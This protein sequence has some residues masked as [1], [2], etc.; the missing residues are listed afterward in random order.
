MGNPLSRLPQN[1][2]DT[3]DEFF[4]PRYR[5]RLHRIFFES[6]PDPIIWS[7]EQGCILQVNPEAERQFGY[8]QEEL[9]GESLDKLIPEFDRITRQSHL[10]ALQSTPGFHPVNDGVEMFAYRKD[11]SDFPIDLILNPVPTEKGF[12]FYS[13]IRN[14]G[15]RGAAKRVRRHLAFEQAVVGLSARFINLPADRV[16]EEINHGLQILAEAMDADRVTFGKFDPTSDELVVTHEWVRSGFP[17]F[18]IRI[19]NGMLPWLENRIRQGIITGVE[20]PSDLP[21]EAEIERALMES[22]GVKSALVVPFR[23]GG[24]VTGGMGISFF[25]HHWNWD[26]I[27]LSRVKDTADIFA[28]ALARKRADADLQNALAEIRKLKDQLE[29]E[30]VYLRE[31]IKLDHAHTGVVANSVAMRGVLKKAEQVAATDSAV[32][33]LGET[34]TGKE[35][36]ARTI[37]D[38]SRRSSHSMI[39]I[40][41]AALPATLIESELFGREKG[42][43]TGA[44]ARQMGRFELA[45]H[46]TIFLDEIGELPPELQPKLLRVLQEGEFERLGSPRTLRVDAR[47]IAATSRDLPAMV[48]EGKFREDL[49][50]RLNI[51]PIVIPPLRVRPEDIPAL[52]WHILHDLGKRMGRGI[53]GVHA[54]TMR[55]FQAYDWPGNVRELRNVI[56]RNLI[57]NSAPVFRADPSTLERLQRQGPQRMNDVEANHMRSV[58]QS[59]QWRVRGRGGAAEI[60]GFK[61]TTLEARMAKLGIRRPPSAA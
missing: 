36:I 40:N 47:V 46:S 25:C 8:R 55:D 39:K 3:A 48:K 56:E 26:E 27:I 52:V 28:N 42:A 34:G 5:E 29:R 1:Q 11:G 59:T 9:L 4:E 43:F 50:Y 37:H 17:A 45:D 13:I 58:L 15:E 10:V 2:N 14:L 44:L 57:L 20:K 35:L 21:P 33:I 23:V 38:L 49:F 22:T 18:G 53:E 51:F 7:D 19:L 32:L 31:E 6:A 41:C 60:L 16:D 54:A 30:N 61:P 24:Q 12:T